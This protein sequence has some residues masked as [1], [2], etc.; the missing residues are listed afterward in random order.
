MVDGLQLDASVLGRSRKGRVN[1][2]NKHTAAYRPQQPAA[3][4]GALIDSV[5]FQ[6]L[7]LQN[8]PLYCKVQCACSAVTFD[9][10]GG[11]DFLFVCVFFFIV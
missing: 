4:A 11:V 3:V 2:H 5:R 9:N 6:I 7:Q 10:D 1:K 8:S